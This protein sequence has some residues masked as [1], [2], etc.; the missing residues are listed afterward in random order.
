MGAI[1]NWGISHPITRTSKER[2]TRRRILIPRV[3]GF[4]RMSRM[5]FGVLDARLLV[6]A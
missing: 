2:R 6:M 1:R 4:A 5:L 3:V